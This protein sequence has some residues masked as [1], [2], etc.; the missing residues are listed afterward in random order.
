MLLKSSGDTLDDDLRGSDL[1]GSLI[2]VPS[3]HFVGLGDIEERRLVKAIDFKGVHVT[4]CEGV[5]LSRD[6]HVRWGAWDGIE[7]LFGLKV[8]D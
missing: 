7:L 3:G 5:A 1:R 6:K 4:R 8:W 2:D